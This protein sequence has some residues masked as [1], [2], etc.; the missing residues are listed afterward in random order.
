MYC[1]LMENIDDKEKSQIIRT[2]SKFFSGKTMLTHTTQ[3]GFAIFIDSKKAI[4]LDLN[5]KLAKGIIYPDYTKGLAMTVIDAVFIRH[6]LR[7]REEMLK[8]LNL[9][10]LPWTLKPC[11]YIELS[12]GQKFSLPS[13]L[14]K[15][16]SS[17]RRDT[18]TL[19]S[20]LWKFM[21]Y[22]KITFTLPHG[23]LNIVDNNDLSSMLKSEFIYSGIRTEKGITLN[24]K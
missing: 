11:Y 12:N 24:L 19:S 9:E 10:K 16:L 18:I 1:K 20:G 14:S 23:Q 4:L 3:D 6:L 22:Y 7:L 17:M 13:L 15:Y 21:W 5:L 2:L 8:K